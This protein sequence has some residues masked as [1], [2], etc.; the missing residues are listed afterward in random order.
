ME[1][2]LS[3][4]FELENAEL[5][6]AH[7]KLT[8]VEILYKELGNACVEGSNGKWLRMA[9]QVLGRNSIDRLDLSEG[10][11]NL[12]Q[13]GH[14]KYRNMLLKGVANC[15]KTFLLNPLNVVFK[16]F[17]NPAMT[18]SAWPWAEIAKVIF[19]NDFRWCARIIPWHGFL[20]LLEGQKVH[21]PA[22]KTHFS[23]GIEFM[24]DTPIFCT[25][26]EEFSLMHGGVLDERET[27]MMRF[28]WKV[29]TFYFQIPQEE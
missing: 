17:S 28:R 8:R 23:W 25:S 6:L 10:V 7:S 14:R 27:K 9:E 18:I 5:D 20:L 19:L 24:R 15:G 3:V 22:P 12:L 4:S 11:Q 2:A 29:F 21:L 1:E 26:K 13:E 16:T